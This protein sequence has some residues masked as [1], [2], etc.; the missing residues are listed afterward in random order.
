MYSIIYWRNSKQLFALTNK[1]NEMVVL[2]TI[3]EADKM[4]DLLEGDS[5]K[6]PE[7]IDL[8]FIDISDEIEARVISTDSVHV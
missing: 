7:D 2:D 4:A 5:Y 1:Q 8:R 3:E 6:L